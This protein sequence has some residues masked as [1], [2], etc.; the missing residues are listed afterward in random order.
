M[1]VTKNTSGRSMKIGTVI[2]DGTVLDFLPSHPGERSLHL[3]LNKL[4]LDGVG[5]RHPISYR[6]TIFETKPPGEIQSSGQFGPWNP[7]DPGRTALKGSYTFRNANLAFFKAVSG[8]LFSSGKF[9]GILDHIEVAGTTDTPN[10]QVNDTS[11]T[12]RLTTEFHAAV[13]GRGG[14]TFLENVIGHFDRTT[15]EATGRVAGENGKLV[16]LDFF[17]TDGRIEDLLN[18]FIKAK[19]PPATGSVIFR[20]HVEVPP[21]SE[22]FKKKLKLV[23]DFGIGGGKFTNPGTQGSIGRLSESAQKA[24]KREHPED[25]STVLSN[26]KGHVVARDGIATLSNVSF[27][28]PGAYARMY[29][30]YSLIDYTVDLH[31]TLITTGKVADATSGFKAVLVKAI[32]PFFKKRASAKIVHFKITGKYQHT[33]VSLALHQKQ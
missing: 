28:V 30:T 12:R 33:T 8:T 27:S 22:S 20:A 3:V 1:P 6:A 17:G 32:T 10:F 16:S 9:S 2:A 4:A 24:E 23:G 13:D 25:P 19:R 15:L 7:D 31:G 14:D 5:E 21:E 18:L 26:L 11:H 29:G